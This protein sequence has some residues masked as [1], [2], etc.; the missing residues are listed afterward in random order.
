MWDL[1]ILVSLSGIPDDRQ[2]VQEHGHRCR[3]LNRRLL[4]IGRVFKTELLLAIKVRH[5]NRP[6]T[7]EQ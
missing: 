5:F 3:S 4:S 2:A 6:T 7:R 1:K